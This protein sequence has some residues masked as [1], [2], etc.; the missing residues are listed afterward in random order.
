MYTIFKKKRYTSKQLIFDQQA[1]FILF[2][3][4]V[5]L[6][7]SRNNIPDLKWLQTII[8]IYVVET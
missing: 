6:Q 1:K 7:Q 5:Y 4:T 3:I 8:V 2:L